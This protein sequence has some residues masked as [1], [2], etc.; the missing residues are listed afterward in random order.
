LGSGYGKLAWFVRT[1]AVLAVTAGLAADAAP[2]KKEV[3][4]RAAA[5]VDAQIELLPQLVAE[6]R[7]TQTLRRRIDG[8]ITRQRKLVADFAWVR[9]EGTTEALGVREV[10]E[11]DGQ[12]VP[13]T[14][15]L[16]R[17]L[18]GEMPRSG[19]AARDLLAE[20]ARYNLA[21]G[22]RNVN[23]PTMTMFLLRRDTQPRFQWKQAKDPSRQLTILS[24][25]ER[26]RPTVIRATNN[27]AVFSHGRIWV[28]PETGA[29]SHTELRADIDSANYV[30]VVEFSIDRSINAVLPRRLQEYY[31][32]PEQFLESVAEYTNYRRFQT[33]GRLVR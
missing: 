16:E 4:R 1:A 3:L 9:V 25:K 18:R 8:P 6:E 20:S 33:E 2:S 30:L 24:F 29:V 21:A 10:R 14:G 22:S 17:L 5:Y 11:A 13:T 12:P 7:S 19:S 32:T 27:R 23:L 28:N 31:V 15:R 26:D